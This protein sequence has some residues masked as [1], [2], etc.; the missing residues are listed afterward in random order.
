VVLQDTVDGP[1]TPWTHLE[2]QVD[3]RRAGNA[4]LNHVGG[5]TEERVLQAIGDLAGDILPRDDRDFGAAAHESHQCVHRRIGSTLTLGDLDQGHQMGWKPEVER[6]RSF[7]MPKAHDNVGD[8][9]PGGIG[10]Q[11][12]ISAAYILELRP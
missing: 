1:P 9:Q 8:P 10:G 5:L 12:S 3:I 4:L 2:C 11:K 7:G 6:R